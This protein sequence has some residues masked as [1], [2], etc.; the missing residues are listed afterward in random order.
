MHFGGHRY[1]PT[2]WEFPSGYKWAFL[3]EPAAAFVI[4]RH[5]TEGIDRKMRGW[6]G[7]S[8]QVQ[9]LDRAGFQRHGWAWLD[10][11]RRGEIIDADEDESRWRVRLHF[12]SPSGEQGSYEGTVKV[13]RELAAYGCG[14]EWGEDDFTINEY[15]LEWF[16]EV[17]NN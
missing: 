4:G 5:G 1:A 13:A 17:L 14:P 6:S 10:Y 11:Q 16:Q 7:A 9:V 12:Q 2:A 15:A 3:D 8:L